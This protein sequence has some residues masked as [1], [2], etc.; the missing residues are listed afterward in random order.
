MGRSELLF[1]PPY[2]TLRH[3]T[4]PYPTLP[5]P[6][7]P[8]PTPPHPTLPHPTPPHP[9][10][11]ISPG[12]NLIR[13]KGL[14]GKSKKNGGRSGGAPGGA[15]K[16][17]GKEDSDAYPQGEG[18]LFE[19]HQGGGG[20]QGQG[21]G[22]LQHGSQGGAVFARQPAPFGRGGSD[23][24]SISARAPGAG[25]AWVAAGAG[26]VGALGGAAVFLVAAS[27]L[28]RLRRDNV[29]GGTVAMRRA[30]M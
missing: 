16:D 3:P 18:P 14:G 26:A 6:T 19:Q 30:R 17:G 23:S 29:R 5:H 13:L 28:R 25:E 1:A 11:A 12:N 4:P 8:H 22:E 7:P 24:G 27:A 10:Q 15:L 9:T 21:R 20:T 2:A